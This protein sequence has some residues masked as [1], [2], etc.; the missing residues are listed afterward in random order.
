MLKI[1]KK[2]KYIVIVCNFVRIGCFVV[3]GFFKTDFL[4]FYIMIFVLTI[5]ALFENIIAEYICLVNTKKLNERYPNKVN[6]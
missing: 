1:F 6:N 2:T 3:I 5:C 4:L